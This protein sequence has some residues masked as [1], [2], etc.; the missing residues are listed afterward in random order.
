MLALLAPL[1]LPAVDY[2]QSIFG[3]KRI[4]G[5][6]RVRVELC[7]G[8]GCVFFCIDRPPHIYQVTILIRK[9]VTN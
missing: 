8:F 4:H 6:D 3:K 9:G 5:A 7:A 1:A 2:L